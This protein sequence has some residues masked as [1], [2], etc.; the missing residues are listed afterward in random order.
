MDPKP[1]LFK[2]SASPGGGSGGPRICSPPP[3]LTSAGPFCPPDSSPSAGAGAGGLY[4][5]VIAAPCKPLAPSSP[6]PLPPPPPPSSTNA[7]YTVLVEDPASAS[8]PLRRRS[9]RRSCEEGSGKSL[10]AGQGR[11]QLL[12]KSPAQVETEVFLGEAVSAKSRLRHLSDPLVLKQP[13]EEVAVLRLL[14]QTPLHHSAHIPVPRQR[15]LSEKAGIDEVMAAAVLTSLSTSPVVLN[16]AH[17]SFSTESRC[18]PWKEGRAMSSSGSSGSNTSADWSWD[19]PSDLS[20]PSTPSPPL[21]TDAATSFLASL[22]SDIEEAEA[23]HFLFGGLRPLMLYNILSLQNSTKVMFKCLWKNCGKVL[24]SSSGMQ[25]HI[26]T[27]HLGRKADLDHS[28]GEED[29]YYTEL[30][31]NVDSLTDGLSSLTPVSPTSS[32]P[33]AFPTLEEVPPTPPI[34]FKTEVPMASPLGHSAPVTILSQSAPTSL[35]HIQTDHAYQAV[36]PSGVL[37]D[38]KAPSPGMEISISW[39]KQPTFFPPPLSPVLFKSPS[40]CLTPIRPAD[41]GEKRPQAPSVAVAKSHPLVPSSMPKPTT[42]TRKP[43]GEAK[44]CRKVY[45]MENRSMWCTACRWKKAC[46][47]FVD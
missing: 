45:G 30:D 4:C 25:K 10:A 37:T 31:V 11:L 18:D 43:R 22:P 3:G 19:P 33:P 14:D 15:K 7:V 42:G 38:L 21:S 26:R 2:R 34:P 1:R 39:Q 44:K 28:D 12:Q 20:T 9:R 32:V 6:T 17:N 46:Q 16:N 36:G 13:E 35:C 23:T 24:S 29:F 8:S 5:G 47:R 41:I 40:G 27:I